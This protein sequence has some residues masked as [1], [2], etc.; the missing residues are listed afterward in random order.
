MEQKYTLITGCFDIL[1]IGH[2]KLFQFAKETF[3]D[4][5]LVIALDTDARVKRLKGEDRPINSALDRRYFLLG[6]KYIS[7]TL[8]FDR[9]QELDEICNI[10]NNPIRIVGEDHI[11][12]T[13]LSKKHCSAIVYFNRIPDYSTTNIIKRINEQN[14]ITNS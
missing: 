5:T 8:F 11:G 2:M 3:P 12:K 9:E 10:L 7:F 1:H 4:R 6:I 13:I 14:S